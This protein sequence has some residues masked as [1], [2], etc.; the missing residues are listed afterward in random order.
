MPDTGA[1]VH[2]I[3]GA[4]EDEANFGNI[5]EKNVFELKGIF[6]PSLMIKRLERVDRTL[7]G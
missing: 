2:K 5:L 4:K 1:K 7:S 3:T 6:P